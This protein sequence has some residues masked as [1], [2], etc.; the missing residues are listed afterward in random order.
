MYSP[1]MNEDARQM[2]APQKLEIGLLNESHFMY[3]HNAVVS[4]E[5][6]NQGGGVAGGLLARGYQPFYAQIS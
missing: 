3:F 6:A 2:L 1:I 5:S 4:G